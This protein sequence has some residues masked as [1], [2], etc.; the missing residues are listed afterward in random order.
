MK[1][2]ES[3]AILI[4]NYK[5][6]TYAAELDKNRSSGVAR[7]EAKLFFNPDQLVIFG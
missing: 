3:Q 2:L 4:I 5:S 7:Y 6:Q 1:A